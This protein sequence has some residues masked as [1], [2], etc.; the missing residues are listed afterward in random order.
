[1]QDTL[2]YMNDLA[3]TFVLII[4]APVDRKLDDFVDFYS[5]DHTMTCQLY[6]ICDT[7]RRF[8]IFARKIQSLRIS[9]RF[10]GD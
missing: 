7:I 4:D 3:L 2:L 5:L 6:S 8:K 9:L 1:M 10:D